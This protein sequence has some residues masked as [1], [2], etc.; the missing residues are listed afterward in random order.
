MEADIVAVELYDPSG[1]LVGSVDLA[2]E[3]QTTAMIHAEL[4]RHYIEKMEKRG[5]KDL[6]VV[7]VAPTAEIALEELPHLQV[8]LMLVDMSLPAMSGIELITIASRQYPAIRYLMVSGHN[9]P[10]YIQR[11]MA[12]GAQGYVPKEN[13]VALLEAVRAVIAG[14]TYLGGKNL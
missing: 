4:Y 10:D 13:P 8:D 5:Q 1:S 14:E 2:G 6:T 9:E 7:A 3:G 12:A 11:A